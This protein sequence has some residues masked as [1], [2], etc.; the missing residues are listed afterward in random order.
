MI[1]TITPEK[2]T[3]ITNLKTRLNDASLSNVGNA[4]TLDLFKLYNENKYSFSK[5]FLFLDLEKQIN[6]IANLELTIE[7]YKSSKVTIKFDNTIDYINSSFIDEKYNLGILD[8]TLFTLLEKL[9]EKLVLF[10]QQKL[11]D[12]ETFLDENLLILKQ[13][14]YGEKGD[15]KL[16]FSDQD[17]QVFKSKVNNDF[18][19][20]RIDYSAILIKFDIEKFKN[21]WIKITNNNIDTN[22]VFNNMEVKLLL[23]DVTMG[24]IK[25]YDYN[26]AAYELNKDFIE[27]KGKDTINFSDSD[28]C[29]FIKINK[30]ENWQIKEYFKSSLDIN[31]ENIYIS[32][33]F[34]SGVED[35][36][37][38]ITDYF[39]D[40]IINGNDKG[41]IISFAD[42]V[43]FNNKTYF[44]KRFGSR[45]LLNKSLVPVVEIHIDQTQNFINDY[46]NDERVFDKI[47]DF[48]VFN[49]NIPAGYTLKY[50][51]LKDKDDITNEIEPLKTGEINTELYDFIGN[52][53]VNSYKFSE[54]IEFSLIKINES[55]LYLD[56]YIENLVN[57]QIVLKQ[58]RYKYT[59]TFSINQNLNSNENFILK[60]DHDLYANNSIYKFSI[61]IH[62]SNKFIN[63]VKMPY[64]LKSEY[65]NDFIHYKIIDADTNLTLVDYNEFST[66]LKWTGK[67]Y[68]TSIFIP[69]VYKNKRIKFEFKIKE[70][71]SSNERFILN[72]KQIFKVN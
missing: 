36:N 13:N 53:I 4:A 62:D 35:L 28:V 39:I 67:N 22:S 48:Y 1:I 64:E 51:F 40:K 18:Y 54:T 8:Q 61:F 44:V 63:A 12:I 50:R 52:E 26:I 49:V 24:N 59:N 16:L 71:N 58:I 72:E 14:Q 57:E 37:I 17:Q 27:G 70:K 31:N 33:D 34:K 69:E 56:V 45:H 47:E 42:D 11:I 32:N 65:Y 38:D 19:F 5:F 20:S 66:K 46:N 15:K 41:L 7:D 25:P 55:Y 60:F 6:D 30:N 29:N 10:K 3:Y 21:N 23:K 2:D 68:T 43:L 9:N